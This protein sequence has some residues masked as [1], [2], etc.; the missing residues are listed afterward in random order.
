MDL[1]LEN[2][3]VSKSDVAKITDFG[4]AVKTRGLRQL[5]YKSKGGTRWYKPPEQLSLGQFDSTVGVF[6]L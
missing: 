4:F 3:L 6:V 5:H 2:I 1:K